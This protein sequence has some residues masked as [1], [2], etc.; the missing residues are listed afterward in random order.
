MIRVLNILLSCVIL[1]LA[2]SACV[3]PDDTSQTVSIRHVK[4]L[5]MGYPKPITSPWYIEG[6]IISSDKEG[7]FYKTIVVEDNSGAI[8]IRVDQ[9]D[10]H[11]I[12]PWCSGIR[13]YIGD[14]WLGGYGYALALGN[15]PQKPEPISNL[16]FQYFQKV[17]EPFHIDSPYRP[18]L[19]TIGTISRNDIQRW[20][21]LDSVQFIDNELGMCWA[22]KDSTRTYRHIVDRKGD[23]L[24]VTTSGYASY[25]DTKIPSGAGHIDGILYLRGGTYE[26]HPISSAQAKMTAPRF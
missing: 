10:L 22:D 14:M 9:T 19:R 23:T 17:A 20:I 6:R 25:A 12:Y 7:N 21:G 4:S 3:T 24:R 1:T 5:Y 11:S 15:K 16:H 8:E 13:I 2:V 18:T 26:L